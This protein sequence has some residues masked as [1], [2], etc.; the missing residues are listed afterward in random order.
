[1]TQSNGDPN[2]NNFGQKI[3]SATQKFWS[4]LDYPLVTFFAFVTFCIGMCWF[5]QE[6]PLGAISNNPFLTILFVAFIFILV[7][8]LLWKIPQWQIENKGF[9]IQANKELP[10]K[11]RLEMEDV[12]RK[13]LAQVLGGT[14]VLFT[15]YTT[16]VGLINTQEA[17]FINR[18]GSS[19]DKLASQSQEVQ[20]GS[21]LALERLA[22]DSRKD[23]QFV[24]SFLNLFIRD[25]LFNVNDKKRKE[26]F[27][28]RPGPEMNI[29]AALN[30]VKQRNTLYDREDFRIDFS[31]LFL[32]KASL[33]GNNS[34]LSMIDLHHADLRGADLRGADLHGAD[35]RNSNLYGAD[36]RGANLS[37]AD[38]S[39]ASLKGADLRNI[40]KDDKT[41][42][43]TYDPY[44]YNNPIPLEDINC[45]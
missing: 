5:G 30:A 36:L 29:H 12:L 2:D 34:H 26:G 4:R 35:L 1:M 11:E 23:H 9:D 41:K 7:V 37:G 32:C 17:Q 39:G 38:L 25:R 8:L 18:Y 43:I 27:T 24:M 28:T 42:G 40:R 3:Y 14:F 15:V 19:L 33:G 45:M 6:N 16:I 44:S 22:L 10:M 13:S 31:N 20:T 21:I